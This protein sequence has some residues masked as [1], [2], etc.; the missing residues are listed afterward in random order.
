MAISLMRPKM[1]AMEVNLATGGSTI[2]VVVVYASESPG[3]VSLIHCTRKVRWQTSHTEDFNAPEIGWS[4][5]TAPE[6]TLA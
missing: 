4:C 1:P 6:H 3:A 5:E 2:S